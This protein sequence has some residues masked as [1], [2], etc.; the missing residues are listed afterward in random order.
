MNKETAM[1][2]SDEWQ[3]LSASE[4]LRTAN[5]L[6]NSKIAFA[7]SLGLEDQV[8]TH[9]IANHCSDIQL[10][11]LDTGRLFPE[12]YDLIERTIA[13]YKLKINVFYPDTLQVENMVNQNG[14]NL[15]YN[16][17]ENRKLC[18]TVRK[19]LPLQRALRPLNAWITGLRR[20]QA[21]TR[22]KAELVEWDEIHQITKINPLINWSEAD[23]IQFIKENKVPYNTLHDKGFPSIG[24]Q[25][26]T[27]AIATNE[28]I[29]A[30]RWWWELPEQKE[31]GLHKQ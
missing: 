15:F 12:T 2:L 18:C 6:F 20:S 25:P 28:D 22:A 29:R 19:T 24:C 26:C 9:I 21:I 13:R 4:L 17:I 11:T 3:N 23:V 31:C 16:S 1:K 7:N 5:S 10:F 8:I 14:I 30:G 27:R